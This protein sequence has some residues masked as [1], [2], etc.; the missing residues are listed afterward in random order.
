ML[1]PLGALFC[2]L[3]T[4]GVTLSGIDALPL[5]VLFASPVPFPVPFRPILLAI[6]LLAMIMVTLIVALVAWLAARSAAPR[7]GFA[8]VFFGCW[9]AVIIGGWLA[10]LAASPLVVIDFQYPA[11]MVGQLILQRV[12]SGGGWGLYWGWLIG[13]ICAVI[14]VISNR[15]VRGNPTEPRMTP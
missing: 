7:R 6:M 2:G 13:L 11:D 9:F 10:A 5:R 8:A 4:F 15:P 14:F 1:A 3:I 12:S